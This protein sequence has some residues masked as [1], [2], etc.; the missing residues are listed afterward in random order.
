LRAGAH[1][2]DLAEL[3]DGNERAADITA[4]VPALE[5]YRRGIGHG[6]VVNFDNI[7][8]VNFDNI[9]V[10]ATAWNMSWPWPIWRAPL[11]EPPD[12]E[13]HTATMRRATLTGLP[14]DA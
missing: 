7:A 8:V 9:V 14:G 11:S 2:H 4:R 1:E 6:A 10:A 5:V 3:A 12:P 13:D